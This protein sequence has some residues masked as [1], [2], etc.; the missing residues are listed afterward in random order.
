V[1][2]E[3]ITAV[4]IGMTFNALTFVLGILVGCSLRKES[5]HDDDDEGAE[6]H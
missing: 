2:L 1:T 6:G 4:C 5:R 3:Q